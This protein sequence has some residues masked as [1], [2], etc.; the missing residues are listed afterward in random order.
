MK[1]FEKKRIPPF[2]SQTFTADDFVPSTVIKPMVTEDPASI[3]QEILP[4]DDLENEDPTSRNISD[5]R[6]LP[7]FVAQEQKRDC[8]KVVTSPLKKIVGHPVKS[9]ESC[10]KRFAKNPTERMETEFS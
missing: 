1:C 5:I 9:K 6:P 8:S 7:R 3:S 10:P 2:C 4:V